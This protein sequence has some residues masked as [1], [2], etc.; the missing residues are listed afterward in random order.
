MCI[1]FRASVIFFSCAFISTVLGGEV[2]DLEK[3]K[4]CLKNIRQVTFSSMG[5]ERAGESYFSPDGNSIIFQATLH[6]RKDYQI[7]TLDL[8]TNKLLRVSTGEG[9]CTCGF[10]KP[11]GTKILFASSHEAPKEKNSPK[12]SSDKYT[13]DLTPYM[14]IYEANL[15][16]SCL[17]RITS[18]PAYHA[19]CGYSPDGSEIVYASNE[20]GSMNLYIC[21][22]DG[23][24][25]RQLTHKQD[26]YHGGPFFSPDGNQ[27]VFRVDREKK[28]YLQLFLIGADGS[29]E[30]RLTDNQSVNW[31]PYWHPNGKVIAYTTSKHGHR[32]YE[33]YLLNLET[34]QEHRVT[35]DPTFDGLPSFS[36]DG[37][38]MTWTSK[39]GDGTSQVF[40]ADFS[41]PSAFYPN[42]RLL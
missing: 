16:G 19:E 5:F 32:A 22:T 7:Y 12:P 39:R 4:E 9:T 33:I 42:Q 41:F 40:I 2:F 11:D 13:W 37:T 1:F 17:R 36:K 21:K 35:H 34:N 30:R 24:D 28:D 20:D 8:L 10:Y 15:D 38:K 26:C 3:E 27:I 29:N 23:S 31:A 6:G 25:V 18:G 14:N